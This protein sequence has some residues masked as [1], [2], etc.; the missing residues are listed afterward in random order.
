MSGDF[1]VL[2]K[3]S[4]YCHTTCKAE[5]T[6]LSEN[7]MTEPRLLNWLPAQTE[8]ETQIFEA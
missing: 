8:I 2:V 7:E 6:V 1:T 4:Q 3:K 5:E